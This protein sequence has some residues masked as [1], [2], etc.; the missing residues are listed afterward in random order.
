MTEIG[1]NWRFGVSGMLRDCL[2]RLIAQIVVSAFLA[3][4]SPAAGT[5]T[6]LIERCGQI[7]LILHASA[8]LVASQL[9]LRVLR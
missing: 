9:V 4:A 5:Q 2:M 8:P 6:A 3:V 7:V 1:L